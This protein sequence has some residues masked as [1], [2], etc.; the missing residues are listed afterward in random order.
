MSFN[1]RAYNYYQTKYKDYTN[2]KEELRTIPKSK[3]LL[4][5]RCASFFGIALGVNI[6]DKNYKPNLLTYF[7]GMIMLDYFVTTSYSW[8]YYWRQK[9]YVETLTV[10]CI[11]GIVV[12][13]SMAL[14]WKIT[15]LIV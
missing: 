9:N 1:T 13:V 3:A 12:P 2:Y 8:Y 7:L 11:H 10:I 6:W 14:N 5:Q 15:Q 4:I